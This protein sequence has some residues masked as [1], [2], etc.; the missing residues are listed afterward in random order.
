MSEKKEAQEQD[1]SLDVLSWHHARYPVLAQRQENLKK[2]AGPLTRFIQTETSSAIVL[3]LAAV[4]ALLWANS[5]WSDQYFDLLHAHIHVDIGFWELNESVHFWVND[6]LMVVFFFLVG[7]EIKRE[8]VAG[9]LANP[10]AVI[11]PIVAAV[12]GMVVPALLYFWFNTGG[13]GLNGWG[14]PVATDIAFAIGVLTLAGSR[15]P[16]SL[17]IMLLALAVVDDIGGILIIALFYTEELNLVPLAMAGGTL[18]VAYLAQ[19]NGLWYTPLYIALGIF[20]WVAMHDAGIHPTVIGVAFALLTPWQSWYSREGFEE[21]AQ[22]ALGKYKESADSITTAEKEDSEHSSEVGALIQLHEEATRALSPLDRLEHSLQP[23]VAFGI[24]PI[25]AFV[26]AGVMLSSDVISDA[27]VSPITLGVG[28]GLVLG[29]PIGI[30][31]FTW[32]AVRLGAT[33][34][35]G[36][37]YLA[38]VGVGLLGGIGFTVSLLIADLSFPESQQILD[39]AKIGIIVASLLAGVFGFIVLRIAYREGKNPELNEH[40]VFNE[41]E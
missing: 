3:F 25:F 34:P 40:N 24:V 19:K 15:I 16:F 23:M 29:K 22:Q 13:E 11:V 8:I 12:G 37:N 14:I 5:S 30:L 39:Q 35:T 20:G 18:V 28:V 21:G 41:T 10:K 9:E 2:F 26:N 6:I 7:L 32:L 38:V 1:V 27:I 17:R 36:M 4:F 31:V 33:L